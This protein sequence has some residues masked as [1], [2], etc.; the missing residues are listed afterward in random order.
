M[1]PVRAPP[2]GPE[3]HSEHTRDPESLVLVVD[4]GR[5]SVVSVPDGQAP[6]PRPPLILLLPGPASTHLVYGG[7]RL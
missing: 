3:P 6:A 7:G 4:L 1:E 5:P 2:P